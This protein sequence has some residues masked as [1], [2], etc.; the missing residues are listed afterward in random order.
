MS[1]SRQPSEAEAVSVPLEQAPSSGTHVKITLTPPT[2]IAGPDRMEDSYKEAAH[3]PGIVEE[4]QVFQPHDE[5]EVYQQQ[6]SDEKEVYSPVAHAKHVDT[7]EKEVYN[8]GIQDEWAEKEVFHP[9]LHLA[10]AQ[11]ITS[12]EKEVFDPRT[13]ETQLA[14][15][16]LQHGPQQDQPTQ[17]QPSIL[18]RQITSINQAVDKQK[19]ALAALASQSNASIHDQ[20]ARAEQGT[21]SRY[22]H[23]KQGTSAQY[24]HLK[25]GTSSQYTNLK[26][27]TSSQYTNLKQGTSNQWNRL[28]KG[29]NDKVA[30]LKQSVGAKNGGS[31]GED[32]SSE[33]KKAD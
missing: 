31:R 28:G 13:A 26:Q 30:S 9:D 14:D 6:M 11:P 16:S 2:P 10:Q 19:K 15:L 5:K 24:T 17:A 32:G 27:G 4:K 1:E 18:Q 25:K 12:T 23:L 3:L 21:S 20:I 7:T 22:A 29:W 8:P 33:R